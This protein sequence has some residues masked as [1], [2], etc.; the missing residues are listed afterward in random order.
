MSEEKALFVAEPEPHRSA[1]PASPVT[2]FGAAATLPLAL[3]FLA[4]TAILTKL[5]RLSAGGTGAS[6]PFLAD[7]SPDLATICLLL[8]MFLPAVSLSRGGRRRLARGAFIAAVLFALFIAA[9]RHLYAASTGSRLSWTI[10]RYWLRNFSGITDIIRGRITAGAAAAAVGAAAAAAVLAAAPNLR[11]VKARLA[12]SREIAPGVAAV[13]MGGIAVVLAGAVIAGRA[14][15]RSDDPFAFRPSIAEALRGEPAGI[16][17]TV[18]DPEIAR[19]EAP[20][21]LRPAPGAPRPNIVLIILE[22]ENWKWVDL[23]RE[24]GTTPYL[25]SMAARGRTAGRFYTVVPHTTKALVPI[26]TGLYPALEPMERESLAG[27]LPPRG[28]APILKGLGYRTAFFQTA[29]DDFENRTGLVANFGFDLFR[30][31]SDLPAAGFERTNELGS[32]ERMMLRP[33]LEWVDGARDEPF[34][35]TLLTISSHDPYGTPSGFP[36]K[37]YGHKL[38][39]LNDYCNALRYTDDF[40]RDFMDG[41]ERRGLIPNTAFIVVG[42]HGEAFREHVL[43]NHN[44]ILWEEGLR[45]FAVLFGGAVPGGTAPIEGY[46]SVLDVV[47]TVCDLVGIDPEPAAFLGQSLFRPVPPDRLLLFSRWSRTQGLALRRGPVKVIFDDEAYRVEVYDNEADPFDTRNLAYGPGFGEEFLRARALEAR[48][49]A[50]RVDRAYRRWQESSHAWVLGRGRPDVGRP[51]AAGFEGSVELVGFDVSPE[52]VFLGDRVRV[53]AALRFL[54]SGVPGI[55]P[56]LHLRNESG[57][58]ATGFTPG[59]DP[60][61]LEKAKAGDYARIAIDVQVPPDWPPGPV[62]VLFGLRDVPGRR[63]LA[64]ESEAPHADGRVRMTT[65]RLVKPIGPNAGPLPAPRSFISRPA[66]KRGG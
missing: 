50:D 26:L 1:G 31:M 55:R 8:L 21:D 57:A 44:Q 10:V 33:S 13:V 54:K 47:P 40:L 18:S 24:N 60:A 41:M 63:R 45:T 4:V 12:R 61:A 66:E 3:L 53:R 43:V 29:L 38:R 25:K 20:L 30:G 48:A 34:F 16:S 19:W 28:L 46:R 2:R 49:W 52:S 14:P 11:T 35:L 51:L 7:W 64:I 37:D 27:I 58:E 42:D 22:S 17:E 6:R 9:G 5:E 23:F 32:E 15:V 56:F 36:R 59:Q 39:S 65:F 62:E